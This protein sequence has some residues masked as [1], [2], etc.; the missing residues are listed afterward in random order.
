MIHFKMFGVSLI[1]TL[2]LYS[3]KCSDDATSDSNIKVIIIRNS[4]TFSN[5]NLDV[6]ASYPMDK[7]QLTD[8]PTSMSKITYAAGKRIEGKN[9]RLE[10]IRNP[11]KRHTQQVINSLHQY[12]KAIH[13]IRRPIE[14]SS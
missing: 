12:L 2:A 8:Y 10:I 5:E 14:D 3:T 4:R 13:G 1:L 7:K 11:F 9:L 6:D